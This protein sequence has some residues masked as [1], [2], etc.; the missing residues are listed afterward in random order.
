MACD[1]C[2]KKDCSLTDFHGWLKS[3]NVK[4]VCDSCVIL[5]NK[6]FRKLDDIAT[7]WKRKRFKQWLE[8]QI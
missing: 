5:A 3:K 2:G 8:K 4:Q 1:M 6:K 7:R